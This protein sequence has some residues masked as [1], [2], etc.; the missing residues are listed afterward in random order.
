[1]NKQ[2]HTISCSTEY[3]AL[4]NVI[5]TTPKH[6][7]M[8]I[9]GSKNKE[10]NRKLAVKQHKH[11]VKALKE[12]GVNIVNL[13][14][15]KKYPEQVFMRDVGFVIGHIMFVSRLA[16]DVRTGEEEVLKKWLE[17]EHLS[18]YTLIGDTIEGGDVLID[19][20]HVYIGVSNRTSIKAI[21]HIQKI[22][23]HYEVTAVPFHEKYL[24]LDCVFNIIS[25]TEAL[26]LPG[27]I[28]KKVE[29]LLAS[30]YELIP[31]SETDQVLGPNLLSIGNKRI[32]SQLQNKQINEV[33]KKKGYTIIEIDMSEVAKSGGSF[34]CSTLP[35]HRE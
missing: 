4:Q 32:I 6:M 29:K 16:H 31:V 34:R 7:T 5:V 19:N 8:A 3:D 14:Q 28:D 15:R 2:V 11:F 9:K 18:Y 35:L 22:L 24:H 1:M 20:K 13:R 23:P 21:E 26:F 12:N 30:R 25:P 17:K 27:V 10:F 33:L